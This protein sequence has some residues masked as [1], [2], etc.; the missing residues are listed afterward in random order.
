MFRRVFTSDLTVH[1][2]PTDYVGWWNI[3]STSSRLCSP[4]AAS[5]GEWAGIS[6]SLEDV[7]K[8]FLR[9][10]TRDL[11]PNSKMKIWK[12]HIGMWSLFLGSVTCSH[13]RAG[14]AGK[15]PSLLMCP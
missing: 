15:I 11:S 12:F 14:V 6:P 13:Q 5:R 1:R 4:S 10:M 3:F 8:H 2:S 9:V 7:K